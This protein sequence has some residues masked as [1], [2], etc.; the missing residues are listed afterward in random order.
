M[1]YALTWL[2]IVFPMALGATGS[3]IGCMIAGS[4]L[5]GA[6]TREKTG[7]GALIAMSAA[8]SSQT[9]YG[10]V[11]MMVMAGRIDAA[12]KLATYPAAFLAIGMLC[13]I[14]IMTSAVMQGRCC[15]AGIRATIEEKTVYGK[16]WIPVGVTESFAVFAMVFGMIALGK[17][18]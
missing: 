3:A 8:P 4:S 7:H 16:C 17:L 14:A 2:G 6:M 10:L 11:L 13:G 12:T 18:G 15:A 5:A 9:I 1:D